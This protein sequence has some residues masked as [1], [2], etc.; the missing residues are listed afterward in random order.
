MR[1]MGAPTITDLLMLCA[2]ARQ[3]EIDQYEALVGPWRLDDVVEGFLLRRGVKFSLVDEESNVCVAAGGWEPLL[4]GVWQSWMVGTDAYWRK[5]W[6]SITKHTRRLMDTILAD[7]ELGVRRLQTMALESRVKA[8]QWYIDG[9]KMNRESTL[10]NF[11]LNGE[12]VA[13]FVRF[14]EAHHG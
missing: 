9:L 12:T 10:L 13:T 7:D 11:G 1:L 5:Y 2:D 4:Q 14:K 3:D 8:C 6:R